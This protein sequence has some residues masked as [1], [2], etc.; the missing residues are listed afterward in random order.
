MTSCEREDVEGGGVGK[1]RER[2]GVGGGSVGEERGRE[3]VEGYF[4]NVNSMYLMLIQYH[5]D[6]IIISNKCKTFLQ[7]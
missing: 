6:V 4:C 1:K 2:E 7:Y 3:G 5:Y